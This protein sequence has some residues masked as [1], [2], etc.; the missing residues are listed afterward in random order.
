MKSF[1]KFGKEQR[2]DTSAAAREESSIQNESLRMKS[3]EKKLD[4]EI[5]PEEIFYGGA[6]LCAVLVL[7]A[8]IFIYYFYVRGG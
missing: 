3:D 1:F 2:S 7:L 8:V 6:L 5:L 4:G